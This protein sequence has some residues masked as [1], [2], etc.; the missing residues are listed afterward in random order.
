MDGFVAWLR[1]DALSAKAVR[2]FAYSFVSVILFNWYA[3]S[4]PDDRRITGLV[5]SFSS[6][7]DAGLGTAFLATLGTLGLT[8]LLQKSS[9]P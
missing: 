7:W 4:G 1:S 2:T 3:G 8:G 6:Q 9:S 5:D